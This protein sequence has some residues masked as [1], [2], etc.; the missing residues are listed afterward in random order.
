MSSA[1]RTAYDAMVLTLNDWQ[2]DVVEYRCSLSAAEVRRLRGTTSG[3]DCRN[4]KLFVSEVTFQ[5]L[6]EGM[7]DKLNQI[8]T[9][10]KLPTE[11]VDLAIEAGVLATRQDPEFNGFLRA[12]GLAGPAAATGDGP[13]PRRITPNRN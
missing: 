5:G 2:G 11:Q 1:T 10:L 4:L 6:E 7:V 3:W 12:S 9:R 13:A 8:P